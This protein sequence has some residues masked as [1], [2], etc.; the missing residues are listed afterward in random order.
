MEKSSQI[1]WKVVP[2][3]Q[4]FPLKVVPLI[5]VLLYGPCISFYTA[6]FKDPDSYLQTRVS[7]LTAVDPKMT[8]PW[9]RVLPLGAQPAPAR[10]LAAG[11]LWDL[12]PLSAV[13]RYPPPSPHP[14]KPVTTACRLNHAAAYLRYEMAYL[15]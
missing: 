2:L 1:A 9:Q 13:L 7:G 6:G 3:R 15:A 14:F 10:E 4:F 11:D 8:V 5:E 12:S